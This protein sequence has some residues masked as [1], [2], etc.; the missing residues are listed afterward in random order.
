VFFGDPLYP[1]PE[2]ILG[3][4]IAAM[5]KSGIKRL[6]GEE[7]LERGKILQLVC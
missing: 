2:S 6:K 5:F 4:K 7:Q 3:M 1:I